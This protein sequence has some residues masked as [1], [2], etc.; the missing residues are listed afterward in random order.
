MN[1]ILVAIGDEVIR[2]QTINT[3]GALL[4]KTLTQKGFNVLKHVV[5][6]DDIQQ[7]EEDLPA[8]ARQCDLLITTGGLGPTSDDRTRTALSRA[9]DWTFVL[10]EDWLNH[11]QA[12]FSRFDRAL[13]SQ[14]MI[15][16]N[17]F[18]IANTEGTACGFIQ[19]FEQ[20]QISVLPGV[21]GECKAMIS[22]MLE[23]FST[24]FPEQRLKPTSKLHFFGVFERYL[25]HQVQQAVS[26][27]NLDQL[28]WGLY[29]DI[30]AV[31]VVF[32][33]PIEQ[34]EKARTWLLQQYPTKNYSGDLLSDLEPLSQ[35]HDITIIES[36]TAGLMRW[37]ASHYPRL[38]LS[39]DGNQDT[40]QWTLK[41]H[42]EEKKVYIQL[43]K[44]KKLF[45]QQEVMLQGSLT[46]QQYRLA[47]LGFG[48]LVES[49][50][51]GKSELVIDPTVLES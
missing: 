8:L 21:P 31:T 15:P 33:G 2:G 46:K 38:K 16:Q 5:L 9:F 6:T 44:E 39:F 41:M 50:I 10:N 43:L 7:L 45:S 48:L 42:Q 35:Q 32:H 13:Q 27:F 19:S 36:H 11:L 51:W 18:L 34:Q 47:I 1:V 22:F 49:L 20:T 28:Q 40:S 26:A 12:T 25:D 29:P 23:H 24:I 37:Q 14:A 3:N 30:S 17:A 4:A